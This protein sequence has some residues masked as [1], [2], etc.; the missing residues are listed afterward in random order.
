[1]Y[2]RTGKSYSE[3]VR[4]FCLTLHFYSP[5]AYAYVREKFNRTL[6]G[7]TTIRNW[8]S[9]INGSPGITQESI[10]ALQKRVEQ[11][12]SEG[13]EVY[14]CLIFD[15]MAIRRQALW[16]HNAKKYRG[17]V[18]YGKP[19]TTDQRSL[20]L[21]KNTLVFLVSGINESFKIPV[22]YFLVNKLKTDEKA[23]LTN[24]IL[25]KLS[26]IGVKVI[27]MTFDGDP[28]NISMCNRVFSGSAE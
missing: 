26:A 5:R 4:K 23:A 12:K 27:A 19:V 8:Y 10:D 18:D 3:E 25:N 2:G 7:G 24:H 20:P 28:T 16:D 15:E 21:A 17:F 14:A 11:K 1:M 6:P 13:K 22:A 9:S